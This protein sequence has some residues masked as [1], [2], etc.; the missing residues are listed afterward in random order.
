MRFHSAASIA[1]AALTALTLTASTVAPASGAATADQTSS[2]AATAASSRYVALGDSY[3]SGTGTRSSTGSCYRSPYGYPRLIADSSS[4]ALDYQACSGATTGDLLS[5]QI[6]AVTAE[7][8]YVSVTIGGNDVGFASVITA[9]AQPGWMSDCFGKLSAAQSVLRNQLPSRLDSVYQGIRSRAPHA[10]V[11]AA[12]YPLLFNGTDCNLAT[13][14]SDDEMRALNSST[15]ELNTLV[16]RRAAA[17]NLRFVD[18]RPTFAG[19]AWCDSP[20]WINGLSIPVEESFHPNRPGNQGYA[21]AVAAGLGL[22]APALR[23][24]AEAHGT[25]ADRQGRSATPAPARGKGSEASDA[26]VRA[27]ADAVLQMHLDTRKNLSRA[28][29]EGVDRSAVQRAVAKLRSPH[30]DRVRQG[31]SELQRLDAAW[32]AKR[33]NR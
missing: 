10:T 22:Q 12:G 6:S 8:D 25:T 14:F 24:T 20:A 9:C 2:A 30:I 4:L 5:R 23:S 11:A 29:A 3:S 18:V 28:A 16:S 7:T 19:H 15:N 13:F 32:E 1:A 17:A 27:Q 26:S 21:R 31:L 33:A